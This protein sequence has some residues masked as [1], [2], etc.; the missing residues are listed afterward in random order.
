M[1]VVELMAAYQ[2]STGLRCVGPHRP[3]AAKLLPGILTACPKC[4]GYGYLRVEGAESYAAC[5][6][7]DRRGTVPP[8]SDPRMQ[9]IIARIAEQ[10]PG[11]P[12]DAPVIWLPGKGL[13]PLTPSPDNLEAAPAAPS[14]WRR[15]LAFLRR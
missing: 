9:A 11:A 1:S 8:P 10:F 5:T 7:C 6:T 2:R 12:V 4:H 3:L 14:L 15:L 13:T